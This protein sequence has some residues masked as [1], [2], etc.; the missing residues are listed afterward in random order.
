MS[1]PSPEKIPVMKAPTQII[2]RLERNNRELNHLRGIMKSYIYEPKTPGLFER[3]EHLKAW[4]ERL[5]TRNMEVIQSLRGRRKC[6]EEQLEGYLNQISEYHELEK[7][8][9]EYIGMAKMHC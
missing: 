6:M 1:V 9:L 8:I 3:C 7:K 2:Q 5:Q 4:M